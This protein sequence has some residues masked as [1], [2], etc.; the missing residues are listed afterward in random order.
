MM[1]DSSNHP[2]FAHRVISLRCGIQ[3][4]SEDGVP[5]SGPPETITGSRRN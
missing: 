1:L 5:V 2:L 4:L 3:S